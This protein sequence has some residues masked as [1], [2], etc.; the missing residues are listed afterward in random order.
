MSADLRADRSAAPSPEGGPTA[1]TVVEEAP[2]ILGSWRAMY[3]VTI[4]S[5]A[6]V[7]A[8]LWALTKVAS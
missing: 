8:L 2:P 3:A 1:T 5:L 7:V 4:G 6:V